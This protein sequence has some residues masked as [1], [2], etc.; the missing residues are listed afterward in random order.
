MAL[1]ITSIPAAAASV[2]SAS[3][4]VE[5]LLYST[6]S[7]WTGNGGTT[8]SSASKFTV[9]QPA[10][11]YFTFLQNANTLTEKDADGFAPLSDVQKQAAISAMG[12]WSS[13]ANLTFVQT[14]DVAK[15]NIR[16]GTNKQTGSAGYAYTP[17]SSG[18]PVLIANN[19]ASNTNPTPGSFGYET[20][21]HEIGHSLGLKHPGNYSA[22]GTGSEGPYLPS[23]QD[24]TAYS[25]MSYNNNSA[26]GSG[27][28]TP[29]MYDIAAVQ[30]YYGANMGAAPG[31]DTYTMSKSFQTIWDPNGINTLSAA[32]QTA[33]VVIDMRETGFSNI[34]GTLST[35]LAIGTKISNAIGGAGNDTIAQNGL[36]NRIDG[37]AGSDTVIYGGTSSQYRVT[38]VS[39]NAFL[40]SGPEGNDLLIND[41]TIAFGDGVSA[42]I[43]SRS[44]GAFDSQQY[45][46]A[47]PDVYLAFGGNGQAATDHFLN[48]GFQEGRSTVF[49]ALR[50]EASNPDVALA[51][52]TNTGAAMQH[53]LQ[54]GIREGRQATS[55]DPLRYLASNRDLAAAFGTDTNAASAHYVQS[56]IR[57]GRNAIAFDPSAYLA[58]NADL[59]AAFGAGN[60]QAAE[61]HFIQ[62]GRL[63]G[64]P[65]APVTTTVARAAAAPVE[66]LADLQGA[67][68]EEAVAFAAPLVQ[69]A[70]GT[71]SIGDAALTWTT[72]SNHASDAVAGTS[73]SLFGVGSVSRD[74]AALTVDGALVG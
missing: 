38:T 28:T 50:Y 24:N 6:R 73:T 9:G 63:E 69:E 15:A 20:F 48:G 46:A 37:G 43:A 60:L 52:G 70:L 27:A 54:A 42:P 10:T 67:N 26:L 11:V 45:M 23:A 41:E 18:S 29:S 33:T 61:Q 30:Y 8:Y 71:V 4:Y 62:F 72:W 21:L 44:S 49:D 74:F 3:S 39:A 12:Q 65:T 1:S 13:V 14:D 32:G 51:F 55:F 40:V 47:N 58:A 16:F 19:E 31:N 36:N 66:F 25:V 56:G 2:S 35:A 34:T 59:A 5:P 22:W 53:W 64:R 7:H 17:V 57:E 68:V